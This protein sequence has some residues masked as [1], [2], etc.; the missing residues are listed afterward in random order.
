MVSARWATPSV[1]HRIAPGC[2]YAQFGSLSKSVW[3]FFFLSGSGVHCTLE[4]IEHPNP[5]SRSSAGSEAATQ[6]R[7]GVVECSWG[8]AARLHALI[9]RLLAWALCFPP[10]ATEGIAE[11]NKNK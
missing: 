4:C 8:E 10:V 2:L 1:K 5:I 3:V 11:L 7:R 6:Q 9:M